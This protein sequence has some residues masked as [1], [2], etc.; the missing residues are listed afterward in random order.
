MNVHP[1]VSGYTTIQRLAGTPAVRDTAPAAAVAGSD[2]E[3]TALW[4]LLTAEEQ[5]FFRSQA[6]LGP[7]TYGPRRDPVET[8]APTG[9][10]LDVRA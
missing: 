9:Q 7:L 8:G 3:V 6:T 2:G 10:R 1:L 4:D 5:E